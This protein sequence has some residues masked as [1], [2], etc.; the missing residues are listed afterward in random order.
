MRTL[1]LVT[2]LAVAAGAFALAPAAHAATITV[3]TTDDELSVP[4]DG[5]CSL[6][7]AIT[8]A[9]TNAAVD[10][11]T[12]GAAGEDTVV[13]PAG[14]F[15]LAVAGT[16]EDAAA[17]GD[18]DLTE[19]AVVR[20]ASAETTIVDGADLD[21]VFDVTAAGATARLEDLTV[22]N[23]SVADGAGIRNAGT[24][25][26]LRVA[27]SQ[28]QAT[29]NAGGILNAAPAAM[30]TVT[31]STLS[32]NTS[33]QTGGGLGTEGGTVTVRNSTISGNQA[34][35]S[36]GGIA[37]ANG[38]TA[39]LNNA[40]IADNVADANP[41]PPGA[42]GAENNG[43]GIFIGAGNTV[44]VSNTI[45]GTNRDQSSGADARHPDCS[46]TIASQGYN[47]IQDTTGCTVSGT[48]TG[49]ITGQNPQLSPLAD[50]GGTTQTHALRQGSDAVDAGNPAAPGSSGSA[51]EATDQRGVNR[52][53][54]PR[55]DIGAFEREGGGGAPAGPRCLGRP[56]TV[57]G[58]TGND[59]LVGTP[60]PDGIRAKRGDDSVSA[61][62][63]SDTVCG[64]PGI[65]VI[66][67]GPGRDRIGGQADDDRAGGGP[68]PDTVSGNAGNDRLRGSRGR[69]RLHG[70]AGNDVLGGG[71]GFDVCRGGSGADRFRRCERR[72][73]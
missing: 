54:G 15:T 7:E 23:G 16:G 25:T 73:Q 34:E 64:G 10:G 42:C 19:S 52:P 57:D 29:G 13:V 11:C 5:D 32:G 27:V 38:T 56:V 14:T 26:L 53:Q 40:T 45:F 33:G 35:C 1:R 39:T 59:R 62:P 37:L 3:N 22:R 21:R 4:T 41:P 55:C 66:R 9:N 44:N 51:C 67:G 63:R 60:G 24:L 46:G 47:L 50:E 28:N 2:L 61:L 49:N 68:G 71:P 17:T 65:D 20:G 18:L 6:R 58:T 43:G 12:S 31:G 36:G 69:D 8:A 72:I 30:L 70:G 48:T